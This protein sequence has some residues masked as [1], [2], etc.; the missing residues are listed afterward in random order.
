MSVVSIR[1]NPSH[2]VTSPS[3]FG[4]P[5]FWPTAWT[6]ANAGKGWSES[7]L[8]TRLRHLDRLY[9][10]CDA[11]YGAEALDN[12]LGEANASLVHAMVNDFYFELTSEPDYTSTDAQCWDVVRLFVLHFAR[13]WAVRNEAWRSVVASMNGTGRIRE[14]KRGRVKFVR[15][16]PDVTLSELLAVAAPHSRRNP[17]ENLGTQIRNWLIV[18]LLLLCGLRRGEALLLTVDSMKHDLDR[19]SGEIRHWLD[20]TTV[21]NGDRRSTKPGIKTSNS[22]RQI[23]ISVDVAGLIEQYIAEYRRDDGTTQF[24]LT[25][26]DGG[27]LSAES[28]NKLLAQLSAAMSPVALQ[29]FKE[30]TGGKNRISS[31]DLRHTCATVRYGF[32]IQADAD[33]ELTFQRMRAFFGWATNSDMP[34][35]YARAAIEEDLLKSWASLFDKRVHALRGEVI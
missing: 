23:P 20:I 8:K 30:R 18:L 11:Q 7:T 19:Q 33:R 21:E 29:R 12:A 26:K 24:L 14:R 9:L 10:Y 2:V 31:H 27:G 35:L 32:F 34:A 1:A 15:A 16:L 28:V 13:H 22:H 5:R 25:A 17:F 6:L 3:N 4:R